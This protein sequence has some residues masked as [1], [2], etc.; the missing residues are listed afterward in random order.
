[1]KIEYFSIFKE[2]LTDFKGYNFYSK[3][4]FYLYRL[5]FVHS[6]HC[7]HSYPKSCIKVIVTHHK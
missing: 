2:F 7:V 1:M 3:Y 4:L 6:Y 5:K